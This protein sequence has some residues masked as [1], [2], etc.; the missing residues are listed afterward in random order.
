M[1]ATGEQSWRILSDDFRTRFAAQPIEGNP[2]F[3]LLAKDVNR[4][5][6]ARQLVSD[7][8]DEEVPWIVREM[9][10]ISEATLANSDAPPGLELHGEITIG[11]LD[12]FLPHLTDD[13]WDHFDTF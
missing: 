13:A 2:I 3:M 7:V 5:W 6:A 8:P 10:R 12:D 11:D 9:R 4:A 1:P